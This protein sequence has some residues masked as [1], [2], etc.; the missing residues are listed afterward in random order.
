MLGYF[1]SHAIS[2]YERNAAS[3][4]KRSW[5]IVHRVQESVKQQDCLRVCESTTILALGECAP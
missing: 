1:E 2:N 4:E 3:P 5:L